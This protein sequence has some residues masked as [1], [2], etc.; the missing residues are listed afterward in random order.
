MP[1]LPCTSV[2]WANNF[3]TCPTYLSGVRE[4]QLT[5]VCHRFFN[6][7][8]RLNQ[9]VN[10]LKNPRKSLGLL[11]RLVQSTDRRREIMKE[12]MEERPP[13]EFQCLET[14]VYSKFVCRDGTTCVT[15]QWQPFV[16]RETNRPASMRARWSAETHTC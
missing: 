13:D 15:D 12:V 1:C 9:M 7:E 8:T 6:V 16:S 11:L 3:T 14:S 5:V 10:T 2:Q 4:G